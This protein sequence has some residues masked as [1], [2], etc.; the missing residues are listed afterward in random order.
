MS[1]DKDIVPLVNHFIANTRMLTSLFEAE[2]GCFHSNHLLQLEDNNEKKT[3]AND[4][5]MTI[6]NHLQTNPCVLDFQGTLHE[7]LTQYASSLPQEDGQ[8]L[9]DLLIVMRQVI[10]DNHHVMLVN[11]RVLDSN[12]TGIK[13][14]LSSFV[15]NKINEVALPIYGQSGLLEG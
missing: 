6:V 5:L 14:L 3:R 7:K 9:R 12:L 11:K 10:N 1:Y 8:T 15:N 13:D 4:E 2:A